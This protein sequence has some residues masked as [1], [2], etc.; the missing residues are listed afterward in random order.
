[1]AATIVKDMPKPERISRNLSLLS[2]AISFGVYLTGG[3]PILGITQ[4]FKTCLRV[5]CESKKG[6]LFEFDKAAKKMKVYHPAP[7]HTPVGTV[8]APTFTGNA[9]AVHTHTAFSSGGAD[10][11]L[12][13]HQQVKDGAGTATTLQV[14]VD[15]AGQGAVDVPTSGVSAGT[16]AG[17]NSA[18]TFTGTAISAQA[19]TE[20][21]NGTDLSA[22]TDVGFMAVGLG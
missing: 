6:Y 7:A 12:G 10:V 9:L 13:A 1:M 21:P 18:P 14:G 8:G 19:G 5:V 2:G 17:T 15:T 16:P 20:I 3:E 4:M 11:T 22:L